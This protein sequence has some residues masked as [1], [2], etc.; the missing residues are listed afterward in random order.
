MERWMKKQVGLW[1]DHRKAVVVI[2]AAEGEEIKII[3]SG[4]EKHTRFASGSSEDGSAEDVRDRQFAGHL[5]DY[6]DG[7]IASIRDAE[8]I[9]IIGPGEAKG[10]LAKRLERD[11][12]GGRITGIESADKMTD[13]QIAASVRQYFSA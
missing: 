5:A 3:Q 1:I 9:F 4:M 7:V 6:Y 11:A 2:L 10:E 12:L 8:S 13:H